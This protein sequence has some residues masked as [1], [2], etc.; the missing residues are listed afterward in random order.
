M[1][2]NTKL[3]SAKVLSH[4]LSSIVFLNEVAEQMAEQSVDDPDLSHDQRLA[5]I[6]SLD[7]STEEFQ[8]AI[9]MALNPDNWSRFS[10]SRIDTEYVSKPILDGEIGIEDSGE[11]DE[12]LLALCDNVWSDNKKAKK[13]LPFVRKFEFALPADSKDDYGCV[14]DYT[15]VIWT[16][17]DD[18]Q[19]IGWSVSSD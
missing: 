8:R 14:A 5:R 1:T 2:T 7:R 17:Y 10:K 15:L 19:I 16:T 4:V 12:G 13:F 18:S 3:S 9:Q 11:I 6:N